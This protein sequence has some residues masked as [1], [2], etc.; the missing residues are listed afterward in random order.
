M[1]QAQVIDFGSDPY[2]DAIGGFAKNFTETL[3][4]NAAQK[5][6]EDLFKRISDSYGEDASPERIWRDILK[7]EGFDQD[8]K[9]DLL[10]EVKE[11][12]TLSN[13]A[14]KTGYEDAKLALR[15]SELFARNKTNEIA[16][17][18]LDTEEA[19]AATTA[20]ESAR[21]TANDISKFIKDQ[22]TASGSTPTIQ[23]LA[24]YND[25]TRQFMDNPENPLP[26]NQAFQQAYQFKQAQDN[27]INNAPFVTRPKP[28]SESYWGGA[29]PQQYQQA[30]D[31][32]EVEL[33]RMYEEDGITSQTD[34]RKIAKRGLWNDTEITKML[35]T[36]FAQ[37]GRKLRGPKPKDEYTDT[38]DDLIL[39]GG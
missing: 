11:Y 32:A 26:L 4:K 15:T 35:Q 31:N 8:Y 14:K 34:L 3:N 2:A 7:T 5:R 10:K 36:V 22:F 27:I 30:F 13:Q 24:A 23:D 12:A 1:P 38:Q 25:L 37:E 17:R 20:N 19:K 18:R 28:I 9:R 21:K 39:W 33:K 16:E 6:N 29:T